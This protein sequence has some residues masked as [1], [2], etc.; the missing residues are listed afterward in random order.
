MSR[1]CACAHLCKKTLHGRERRAG[2]KLRSASC[3]KWW[4][5]SPPPPSRGRRLE[6]PSPGRPWSSSGAGSTAGRPQSQRKTPTEAGRFPRRVPVWIRNWGSVS[7]AQPPGCPLAPSSSKSL[8]SRSI[9]LCPR[10][11]RRRSPPWPGLRTWRLRPPASREKFESCPL[12]LSCEAPRGY[13]A[14]CFRHPSFCGAQG[15]L[16]PLVL[17]L[18]HL[19]RS[20]VETAMKVSVPHQLK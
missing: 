17:C 6:R 18:P 2:L 11:R 3:G 8:R 7:C 9:G 13:A 16:A 15:L 1:L 19:L 12:P 20:I 10:G 14:W 5:W 4:A